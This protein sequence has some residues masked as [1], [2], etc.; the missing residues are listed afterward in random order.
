MGIVNVTPDSFSDGGLYASPQ[1]AIEHGLQL[2]AE[3]ADV[4]DVGGES[5]RPGSRP[6]EEKEELARVL[7]VVKALASQAKAPVSI[8]TRCA[9]VA[10]EALAAGAAIVNDVTAF[11]GDPGDGRRGGRGRRRRRPHAHA[12]RAALD[13]GPAR[14]RQPDGRHL[15]LSEAQR[16]IGP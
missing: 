11:Q 2:A 8:D 10:R 3:G 6:V 16:P 14:V 9:A 12:R 15:P 13:A 7:P 1:A 5:T 4:L